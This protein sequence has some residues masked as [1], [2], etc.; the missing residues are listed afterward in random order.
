MRKVGIIGA[1]LVGAAAGYLLAITPGVREI[2]LER[3]GV[4]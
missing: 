1:G 2:V 3:V 4:G